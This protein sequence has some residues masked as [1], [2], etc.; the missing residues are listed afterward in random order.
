MRLGNIDFTIMPKV[1][2]R[3]REGVSMSAMLR[4]R[5]WLLYALK[6]MLL[7]AATFLI[8]PVLAGILPFIFERAFQMPA[9][10]FVSGSTLNNALIW[11]VFLLFALLRAL[12]ALR[13]IDHA[14]RVPSIGRWVRRSVAADFVFQIGLTGLVPLMPLPFQFVGERTVVVLVALL[15]G[16]VTGLLQ[17][18]LFEPKSIPS[19]LW[20]GGA[21]L[22]WFL[23]VLAVSVVLSAS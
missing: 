19:R 12:L 4:S 16:I 17:W 13:I 7:I 6:Y 1:L 22:G 5:E 14:V 11:I 21:A 18:L 8:A 9:A 15:G 3:A 10:S 20:I 23:T 2:P